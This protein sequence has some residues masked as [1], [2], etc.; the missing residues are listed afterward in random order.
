MPAD[1]F[2]RAALL[3]EDMQV[4][5]EESFEASISGTSQDTRK[6]VQ[7]LTVRCSLRSW[8]RRAVSWDDL[9]PFACFEN[10]AVVVQ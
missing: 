1:P 8:K 9:S 3:L 10:D 4:R 7:C 5:K 6:Y 2:G